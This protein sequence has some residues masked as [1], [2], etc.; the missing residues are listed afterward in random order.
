MEKICLL[1]GFKENVISLVILFGFCLGYLYFDIKDTFFAR[2]WGQE[3][4][5]AW[6]ETN[7]P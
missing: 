7:Q 5:Q 3:W 4:G 1:A 2:E 6:A